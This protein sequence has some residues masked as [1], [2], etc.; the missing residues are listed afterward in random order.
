M[1]YE[2]SC[3]QIKKLT[4]A[5]KIIKGDYPSLLIQIPV[6]EYCTDTSEKLAVIKHSGKNVLFTILFTGEGKYFNA[7]GMD[8]QVFAQGFLDS[9]DIPEMQPKIN[10]SGQIGYEFIGDGV[11]IS[12]IDLPPIFNKIVSIEK[13]RK[14]S[15]ATFD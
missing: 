2:Q 12:I 15:Q 6:D 5:N 14:I 9:Y 13:T 4:N 7:V 1:T 10:H 8:S 11:T 3:E